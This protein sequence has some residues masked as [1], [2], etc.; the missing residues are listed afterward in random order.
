M[1]TLSPSK[2]EL[3]NVRHTTRGTWAL[4]ALEMPPK[5]EA[6]HATISKG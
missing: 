5:P 4:E 2:S 6:F 1:G 3:S